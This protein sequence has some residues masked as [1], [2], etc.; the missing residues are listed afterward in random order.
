[1]RK[2]PQ[3]RFINRLPF[4]NVLVILVERDAR[5]Q[6]RVCA[7]T[8]LDRLQLIQRVFSA[9]FNFLLGGLF[10]QELRLDVVAEEGAG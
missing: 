9:F 5:R 10:D 2:D 4:G 6:K 1:M 8:E 7:W 3:F